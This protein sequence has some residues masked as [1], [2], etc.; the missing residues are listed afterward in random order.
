M[1]ELSRTM[2]VWLEAFF[3]TYVISVKENINNIDIF[4]TLF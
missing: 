1:D 2:L 3:F 4:K